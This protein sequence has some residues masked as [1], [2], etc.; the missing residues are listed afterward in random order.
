MAPV[1]LI[2]SG[3]DFAGGVPIVLKKV[4]KTLIRQLVEAIV[5]RRIGRLTR[6]HPR[7]SRLA[8][9][10]QTRVAQLAATVVLS[11]SSKETR[12]E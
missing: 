7:H 5:D 9:I 8:T 10:D 4:S 11:P 2:S 1:S 6:G 3:V 12:G